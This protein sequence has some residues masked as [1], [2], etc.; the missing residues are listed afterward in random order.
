MQYAIII[1]EDPA[2]M[3]L[4]DDPA[5]AAAYWQGWTDYGA[6]LAEAGVMRG[7]AGLQA[8]AAATTVR[9][10]DGRAVVQDGPYAATHEQL[11]GFYLIEVDDLDA[12]LAWAAK[13]PAAPAGA[14]E[15]RPLLSMGD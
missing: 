8:P 9:V 10:R 15:V 1:H 5:Q 11:G 4:R 6:A 2:D 3:A 7:G 13:C 14:I 12:A